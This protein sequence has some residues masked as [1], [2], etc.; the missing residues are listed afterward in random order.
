MDQQYP[1][2]RPAMDADPVDNVVDP[3]QSSRGDFAIF[4]LAEL[5]WNPAAVSDGGH[6]LTFHLSR[7]RR[8]HLRAKLR[9][10]ECWDSEL[11]L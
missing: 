3:E 9:N 5:N 8:G 6:P 7:D 11:R 10:P 4:H 2:A 1:S